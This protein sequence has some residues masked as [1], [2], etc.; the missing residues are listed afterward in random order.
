MNTAD[1]WAIV[2]AMRQAEFFCEC[3]NTHAA[4]GTCCQGCFCRK[5]P[6]DVTSYIMLIEHLVA[7]R[8][9]AGRHT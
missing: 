9:S 7:I 1:I 6:Q 3:D 4:V 5:Y 8:E 2:I